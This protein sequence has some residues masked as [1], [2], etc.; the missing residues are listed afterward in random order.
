MTAPHI[1]S[2]DDRRRH[3]DDPAALEILAIREW[4]QELAERAD[5]WLVGRERLRECQAEQTEAREHMAQ[6]EVLRKH[7][8]DRGIRRP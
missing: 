3:R 5:A 1:R 8:R 7:R 2:V 4:A 6:S